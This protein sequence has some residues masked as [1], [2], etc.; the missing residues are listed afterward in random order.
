[1]VSATLEKYWTRA[2]IGHSHIPMMT[3]AAIPMTISTKRS[4]AMWNWDLPSVRPRYWRKTMGGRVM[5]L[6]SVSGAQGQTHV[7]MAIGATCVNRMPYEMGT[8][9]AVHST[10][11]PYGFAPAI[12]VNCG[13]LLVFRR[14][15]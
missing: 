11:S 12:F 10:T 13:Q 2:W 1:M 5:P 6:Q 7:T 14:L 8:V 15:E 9:A 3:A 4:H